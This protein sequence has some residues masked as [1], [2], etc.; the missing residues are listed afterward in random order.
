M[1]GPTFSDIH[2]QKYKETNNSNLF[3]EIIDMLMMDK[4]LGLDDETIDYI[5]NEDKLENK[6]LNI[7]AFILKP[8]CV[9]IRDSFKKLRD[10]STKME[11]L[12]ESL[13]LLNKYIEVGQQEK[14]K[15]GEVFT[16][17]SLVKDMVSNLPNDVW[18]NPNLKWLDPAN[19]MGNFPLVVIYKLMK[20]LE[21]W[22]PDPNKR[23]KH[24]IENMIYVCE[25]QPKNSFMYLSLVDPIDDLAVNLYCGS[26]L[27]DGFDKHK[28]EVWNVDKFDIVM[29][30]PP[31][32]GA[33]KGGGN[34][35]WD[36]FIRKVLKNILSDN[37]HLLFVN[38]SAWRKPPSPRSK[39][40]DLW[41]LMT[42]DNQLKYLE[43]HSSKDGQKVFNAGTRYDLYLI[44]RA[45]KYENSIIIDELGEENII[46]CDEWLFMP[47]YNID[48]VRNIL[49]DGA[50][51]IFDRSMY[52][53]DKDITSNEKD[54]EYKYELIHSTPKKGI[55]YMYSN[56]II[57]HF[58]VPKVIFGESGI[59][60][61]VIDMEGKYGITNSSMGIKVDSLEDAEKLKEY[62]LNDFS[63]IIK[64]CMWGNFRI[65]WRLFKYLKKEF[66][67]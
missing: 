17:L 29:G 21:Q 52:A 58:G 51:I 7:L 55:R 27:D 39:T 59:N 49:G 54:E 33:E 56:E 25:L 30:N 19:G 35:L 6:R 9:E 26:F 67:K 46:D 48:K 41:K 63:D 53:S 20:G 47:N 12:K 38:P 34:S 18:S 31:Y 14:K 50:D 43:I 57:G 23:Y 3:E 66:W 15:Y 5:L 13:L 10:I 32:N 60:H 24:I 64:G 2:Y 8:H 36:K 37:G 28:R 61:V 22:E 11:Y 16:P 62:L 40:R 1:Q 45:K 4:H 42:S 65:D 44:E